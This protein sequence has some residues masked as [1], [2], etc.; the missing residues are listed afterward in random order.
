MESTD[1][2]PELGAAPELGAEARTLLEQLIGQ[3]AELRGEVRSLRAGGLRS[4][5][6]LAALE[7]QQQQQRQQQQQPA[8][9]RA[10]IPETNPEGS[11]ARSDQACELANDLQA[12]TKAMDA[13]CPA[14]ARRLQA[15][16]GDMHWDPTPTGTPSRPTSS[17]G[18]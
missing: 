18:T 10:E 2:V 16:G 17:N 8:D 5:E 3:V 14:R 15:D 9:E 12:L 4:D 7:Q 1:I 11:K 13:C 6:R